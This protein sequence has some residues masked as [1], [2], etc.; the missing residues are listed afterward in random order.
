[1]IVAAHGNVDEYCTANG[2]VIGK[3]YEGEIENYGGPPVVLVT[4]RKLDKHEFY[5]LKLK[6]LRRKVELVSIY[7]E[8]SEVA[9]FVSYVATHGDKRGGRVRFGFKRVNGETVEDAASM[10]VARRIIALRDAG[11]TYRGIVEDEGVRY[12]DGRR[13][14]I[15]TVQIILSNREVYE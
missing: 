14:S 15:S 10:A 1:M 12:P 4:D 13:M 9:E 2:L 6:M 7:W 5:R 8:D 11:V 3:R